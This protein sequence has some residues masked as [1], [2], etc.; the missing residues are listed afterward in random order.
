[1]INAIRNTVYFVVLVLVQVLLLDNI[2]FLRIAT[3]FLYIYFILK[4][5]AS[6]SPVKVTFLSFL[7]GLAVDLLSNTAGM[8]AAACTL[9][10]FARPYLIKL[11]MGDELPDNLVPSFH[12]FGHNIFMRYA[13][14][15]AAL[16]H[17]ALFLI[18]A[19]DLFD[20]LFFAIRLLGSLVMSLLFIGIVE[21][22]NRRSVG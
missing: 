9:A 17:L 21:T 16:H 8:H 18:E 12:T 11:F 6:Y 14:A 2:H 4:L 1:M 7:L 22:F 10:G 15:I 20:P 13:L 19:M 3:P 5:P